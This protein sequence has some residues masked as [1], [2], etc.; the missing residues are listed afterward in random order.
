MKQS[1]LSRTQPW[2]K[3]TAIGAALMVTPLMHALAQTTPAAQNGTNDSDVANAKVYPTVQVVDKPL[4][5]RQFEKV[6][7]TGSAIL[8]KEAKQALPLQYIDR[9]EIERSGA[10]TLAELIQRLPVMSNFSELGSV[11]GTVSGGPETAAV[12]GNQSGTLVL[13]NG[14]RL[15]YYGSQTIVGERAVVDLNFLPLAAIERIEI[16]TDGASSRY[17]SDAVAGVVNIITK[18]EQQGVGIQVGGSLPQGGHGQSQSVNLSWGKGR[19]QRDG[20]N[21]RA[22][23]TA[24]KSEPLLANHRE[25]SSQG[26]RTLQIDGK[27][28]WQKFNYSQYSAPAKNYRDAAGVLR[29]DHFL[30]TGQCATGWYELYRGECDKNTQGDMTLYP[31][32]EKN[33][34]YAQG[35]KVLD[36]RWVLFAEGLVGQYKQITVPSGM[37]VTRDVPNEDASRQYLLDIVPWRL[38]KQQ[39]AN[40]VHNAVVG[41]RGEQSGWDFVTSVSSGKHYVERSYTDG[42]LKGDR[43]A[44]SL[45]PEIIGQEPSQY[46]TTKVSEMESYLRTSKQIMDVGWTRLDSLNFLA[47]REL[48]DTE[49]GPVG[50]GVG[51]DLRREAIFYEAPFYADASEAYRR[52]YRPDFEARR[53]NWATHIE[54]NAPLGPNSEITAAVRH[55]QYSDF[56]GVQTGKAG[57]KWKPHPAWLIRGSVGTGFRAP[58]LGQMLPNKTK[59]Y[60][61]YD[62]ETDKY[63]AAVNQGNP[64]LKPEKSQQTNWGLRFE[65]HQRL[66][67]G[68]DVWQLNIRD[69]FGILT[70]TQILDVP[71]NRARYIVDGELLQSNQ[72]LGKS[73][74]RGV[75]YDVQIR[76]PTDLGR[77][78][79]VL[80]GT[81]M[82]KS[83]QQDALTGAMVSNL[84][85]YGDVWT[86]T[87]ARNQWS[88]SSMLERQDWTVGAALH[89]RSG[90]QEKTVLVDADGQQLDYTGRIPAY[91][92][93]D[94]SSRWQIK[95][96]LQLTAS[97]V[98]V[99]NRLPPLR[100]AIQGNVLLGVDTRYA[101]YM[102]RNLRVKMDYKF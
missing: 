65:P 98:N 89:Y 47:S 93:W 26:A 86:K 25:V 12:H 85:M 90:E 30:Q 40:R 45:P 67:M 71:E 28:W 91:W 82:F 23:L 14:R 21:L 74:Q 101:N 46:G 63:L 15:P 73:I 102:G 76:Q 7:I 43:N 5:Y 19:L 84:A 18:T 8:A 32:T 78:R 97:L 64:L 35:D 17:G 49:N 13:L 9:R 61:V 92:T 10:T 22:Y 4:E 50:V 70:A 16:L 29:N 62:L 100:M 56:S 54:V 24:E 11:T 20:Y 66:S 72:N 38:L 39:Y 88:L 80:R 2:A 36:N 94:L 95:P 3:A 81:Y 59:I 87:A 1:F 96:K 55:D 37:Y 68:A 58:S 41:L 69:T 34:L 57:W 52:S 27:A 44:L 33:L 83:A 99:A 60:D 48:I 51:L 42:I 53:S 31:Q 79:M 77:V 75:D 6:E